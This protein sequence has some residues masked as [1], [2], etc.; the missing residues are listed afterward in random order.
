MHSDGTTSDD[1]DWDAHHT[2]RALADVS[3]IYHAR[4][5]LQPRALQ[6]F[7][8][9][10]SG[11][12]PALLATPTFADM[13][14]VADAVHA[15]A[16]QAQLYDRR[17][18]LAAATA[19]SRRWANG[20]MSNFDYLVLLNTLSGRSHS[21]LAQYPVFPW[22]L[23][24]RD[25]SASYSLVSFYVMLDHDRMIS[26]ATAN[27]S[28]YVAEQI[29]YIRTLLTCT[30]CPKPAMIN[31]CVRIESAGPLIE[32]GRNEC[33]CRIGCRSRSTSVTQPCSAT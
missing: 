14:N 29:L 12:P 8:Y 2:C 18:A 13:T 28:V 4:Y 23:Q 30:A 27:V 6:I 7:F 17:R 11:H 20:D 9:P 32:A 24:V 16:P 10:L 25:A 21:D 33:R 3:E 19:A 22:V 1:S 31:D 26:S 15:G 5:L